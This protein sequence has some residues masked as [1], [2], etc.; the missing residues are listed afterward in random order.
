MVKDIFGPRG[1][2]PVTCIVPVPL[3][4]KGADHQLPQ[5]KRTSSY[6]SEPS[7]IHLY[8]YYYS[9]VCVPSF[10]ADRL[11]HRVRI[12]EVLGFSLDPDH[13]SC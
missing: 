3:E 9:N 6:E 13:A 5:L 1:I 10:T 8:S 2:V 12:R 11:S 7:A 4:I